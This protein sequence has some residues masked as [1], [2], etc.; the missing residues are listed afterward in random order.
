VP[1]GVRHNKRLML[2][3]PDKQQLSGNCAQ[4]VGAGACGARPEFRFLHTTPAA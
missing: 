1:V 4:Q 3:G 2:A